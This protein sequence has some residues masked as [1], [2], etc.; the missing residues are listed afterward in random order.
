ML[1]GFPSCFSLVS[2]S[3]GNPNGFGSFFTINGDQLPDHAHWLSVSTPSSN[4]SSHALLLYILLG[5]YQCL[6]SNGPTAPPSSLCSDSS[7]YLPSFQPP[8][9]PT[10]TQSQSIRG[11]IECPCHGN[12]FSSRCQSPFHDTRQAPAESVA[13]MF[14][15]RGSLP[16]RLCIS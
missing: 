8:A 5:S 13:I 2:M 11:T 12:G 14:G 16:L 9:N 4:P 6:N 7:P 10:T 1:H 3:P 15:S